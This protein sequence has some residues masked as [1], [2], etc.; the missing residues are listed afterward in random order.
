MADA[1]NIRDKAFL[2]GLIAGIDA[3]MAPLL[4]RKTEI[5]QIQAALA[6][7][8][9]EIGRDIEAW[10]AGRASAQKARDLWFPPTE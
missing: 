8:D 4:A 2:D 10:R 1:I 7:E 9:R 3:E 6:A 5:A